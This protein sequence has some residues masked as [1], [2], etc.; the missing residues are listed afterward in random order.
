M[1]DE[2]V[3]L[4]SSYFKHLASLDWLSVDW[5]QS[6]AVIVQLR[7]W[8]RAPLIKVQLGKSNRIDM[9]LPVMFAG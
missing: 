1:I 9:S 2:E 5:D 4:V 3:L 7:S 6:K 8:S